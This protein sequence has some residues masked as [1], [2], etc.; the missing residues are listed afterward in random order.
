MRWNFVII[1]QWF[2]LV[3]S[4]DFMKLVGLN[5]APTALL[6]AKNIKNQSEN[7]GYSDKT[8]SQ[9]SSGI[10]IDPALPPGVISLLTPT[11]ASS[12]YIKSGQKVT[13]EWNY[14]NLIISPSAINVELSCSRN[15]QVYTLAQ[16]QSIRTSSIVWDT[17]KV[18]ESGNLHLITADYTLV[19][20]DAS[21]S[22]SDVA[23]A[24]ELAAF[25][26]SFGVYIP[27]RYMPWPAGAKYV[28]ISIRFGPP[29]LLTIAFTAL[30][31]LLA[32]I[33]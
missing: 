8:T 27:Q 23:S 20:Y 1:L 19:I 4:L 12:T 9:E 2:T 25:T 22:R 30:A 13:F 6:K 15:S 7:H 10:I 11:S 32:I 5:T 16:N 21:R 28:N 24:G 29:A 14:T 3:S 31:S 33:L 18:A 26:F 17:N